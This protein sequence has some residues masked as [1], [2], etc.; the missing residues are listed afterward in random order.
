LYLPA[1]RNRLVLESF[2]TG[3]QLSD[4]ILEALRV[5]EGINKYLSLSPHFMDTIFKDLRIILQ[6]FNLSKNML[7][8]GRQDNQLFLVEVLSLMMTTGNQAKPV[9]LCGNALG[10]IKLISESIV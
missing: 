1:Y 3:G 5:A 6:L 2:H 9:V 7:T 4:F 10:E 8:E